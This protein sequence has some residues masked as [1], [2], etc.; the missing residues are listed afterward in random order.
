MGY[1]AY[2]D[3]SFV[4]S[5]DTPG[6]FD[7]CWEEANVTSTLAPRKERLTSWSLHLRVRNFRATISRGHASTTRRSQTLRFGRLVSAS[8]RN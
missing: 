7:G 3:G 8:L 1:E 4:T 2:L 5:K 6:D